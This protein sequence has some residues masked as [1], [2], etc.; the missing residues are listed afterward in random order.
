MARAANRFIRGRFDRPRSAP[1]GLKKLGVGSC[2]RARNEA[3][4]RP[5]SSETI[6]EVSHSRRQFAELDDTVFSEMTDRVRIAASDAREMLAGRTVWAV[7]SAA[8]GGGVA[9]MMR[10]LLPFWRGAGIDTR[11]VVVRGTEDFFRVTKRLHNHLHGQ[12]GDAG[13]LGPSELDVLDRLGR[14]HAESLLRWIRRGDVVILHD[15]QTAALATALRQAG[16][17]VIWRCHVGMDH[18]NELALQAW[19]FLLLRLAPVDVFVFT[20]HAFVPP[21]LRLE[22]TEIVTPA[23]DPT[24]TK[25]R[26][27]PHGSAL[28]ILRHLGV[29]SGVSSVA[30]RY[31]RPD[32]SEVTIEIQPTVLDTDGP[33]DWEHEPVVLAVSRWDRIKN[34]DGILEAF[35]SHVLPDTAAHLFLVG[36]DPNDVADDPEAASLL[37][38]LRERRRRLEP[39]LR[40]RIHLV[41]LPLGSTEDNAAAVNALQRQAAVVVKKSLQEGFGLGVTEAL[42]KARPVVA[43][44]V[45]GHLEQVEHEHSGLL[46][47]DPGDLAAFGGAVVRLLGD[48]SLASRLG[49]TGRERVRALYLNDWHFLRWVE[50]MKAALEHPRDGAPSGVPHIRRARG[51]LELADH[52]HLTGL[53][54]RRRFERELESRIARFRASRTPTALLSID[55]DGYR[56]VLERHGPRLAELLIQ[57]IADALAAHLHE[58]DALARTGGDEFAALLSPATRDA[59]LAAAEG[60]CAAVRAASPVTGIHAAAAISIGVILL[61]DHTPTCDAALLAADKALYEAKASGGD[62]AVLG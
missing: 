10:T 15:P 62:C 39:R 52:D 55:V 4:R 13:P 56:P 20:R 53:W 59:A 26:P 47:D 60:L 48:P 49:Q 50:V 8:S 35:L 2:G 5:V 57:S 16:A 27:L 11:W 32:R 18:P 37:G 34:L 54:N 6:V 14:L 1:L 22:E 21:W 46:V 42:W 38:A 31:Q 58:S 44:A 7:N 43:S 12:L 41:C 24:A 25:N 29:S 19:H 33:P 36:P 28:A 3:E 51:P 45:G 17:H 9:E 61:G 23:I 30:A 40:R